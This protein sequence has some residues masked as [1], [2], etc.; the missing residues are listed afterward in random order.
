MAP[1]ELTSASVLIVIVFI[2]AF[3][4]MILPRRVRHRFRL[5][6]IFYRLAWAL[7]R[8][9]ALLLPVGA[10]TTRC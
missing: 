5:S 3:Q 7:C 4:S 1:L 9:L 6:F 2:D 8:R 10:G